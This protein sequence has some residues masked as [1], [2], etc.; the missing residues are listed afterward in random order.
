MNR[1]VFAL[2]V[3]AY[4]CAVPAHA[5]RYADIIAPLRD[6]LD[7]APTSTLVSAVHELYARAI[8][9]DDQNWIR[10]GDEG[11]VEFDLARFQ[12]LVLPH[13]PWAY[14]VALFTLRA[15]FE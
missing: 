5:S 7:S 13:A 3:V 14:D 11:L 1:S 12:A 15:G 6:L 8:L 10:D 2:L 4:L 9:A